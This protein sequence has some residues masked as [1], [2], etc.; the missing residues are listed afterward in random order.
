MP[1]LVHLIL[2][3][4]TAGLLMACTECVIMNSDE[5]IFKLIVFVV[6]FG[7]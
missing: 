1:K 5:R 6:N 3:F 7:G 2:F 4:V